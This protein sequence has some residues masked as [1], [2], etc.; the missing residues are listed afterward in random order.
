[1][2]YGGTYETASKKAYIYSLNGKT[3][4]E[5]GDTPDP[6]EVK[7]VTVAQSLEIINAL[8]DGKTTAEEYIVKGYVVKITEISTN[9]GNAT[10]IIADEKNDTTGLTVYRAK[11]CDGEKITDENALKAGDMVEVQGKLQK[12]VKNETVT[13]EVA[14]GGK[15][16]TINGTKFTG[17]E[18]VKV[19]NRYSGAIYNMAGQRIKTPAKGLFIKDG[20]KFFVK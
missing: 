16:L 17:I 15:I 10:F 4:N 13:P 18:E 3:K 12:Y 11:D 1:T 5:G 14:S 6:G 9:Y 7:K 20:K 19:S 8:E 2:N